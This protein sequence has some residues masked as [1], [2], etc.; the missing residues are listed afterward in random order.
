M[1]ME[2]QRVGEKIREERQKAGLSLAQLSAAT[3]VS[4]AHLVR[5]ETKPSNPS[6]EILHRIADALEIT[7]ADLL[8]Q[9]KLSYEPEDDDLSPSLRAFADEAK[10]SQSEI[11]TLASIKFRGG[12]RPRSV[13]RWRYIYDSLRAS[14]SFDRDDDGD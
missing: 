14:E 1:P 4:K 5:L 13:R 12:D 8:G 6:L 9:P 3:G 2:M 11:R 10:L 7:V